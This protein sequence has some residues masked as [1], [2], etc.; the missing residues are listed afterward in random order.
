MYKKKIKKF[1][2][3]IFISIFFSIFFISGWNIIDGNYDKQNKVILFFKE[4][5]PV[6]ISR[7][8]RDIIFVIPDLKTLN[9]DLKIQVQKYE[10]GFEGQ[11]FNEKK[12]AYGDKK[13]DLKSFFLPFPRLDVRA[14]YISTVNSGRAHYLE[15]VKDKVIAISG[16]GKIVFFNKNNI[17][18][19]KLDQKEIPNNLQNL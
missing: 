14:G 15:I 1:L 16:L 4:L 3:I 6:N 8:I 19:K 11:L 9:K 12:V 18:N 5:I 17:L 7:Q 2:I 10:Q 13:I